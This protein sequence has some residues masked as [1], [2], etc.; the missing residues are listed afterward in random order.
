MFLGLGVTRCH[1]I[2]QGQ[3]SDWQQLRVTLVSYGADEINS[4][5]ISPVP[6]LRKRRRHLG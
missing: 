1:K 4:I 2:S 6:A 5:Y 3:I